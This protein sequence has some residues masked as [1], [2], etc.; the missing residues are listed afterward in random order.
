MQDERSEVLNV[1]FL[2]VFSS[3]TSCSLDTQL[4]DLEDRSGTEVVRK[5][6]IDLH[7]P[8]GN[9]SDLLHYLS[10]DISTG[11][12]ELHPRI[13]DRSTKLL[14]TIYNQSWLTWEIPEVYKTANVTAV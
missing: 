1:F 3:E 13:L 2:L 7:D 4:P 9:I 11:P 8:R 12:G 6:R 5:G 14:S 10:M